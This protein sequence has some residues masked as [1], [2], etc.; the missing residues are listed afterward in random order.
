[1]LENVLA[2][3]IFGGLAG[4]IASIIAGTNQQM[5][6][7]ANVAVGI[8]GAIVGGAIVRL[9]GGAGTTGF[10]LY[11]LLVAILGAVVILWLARSLMGSSKPAKKK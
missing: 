5:G 7:V 2:W 6:V 9:I 8:V 4:W 3:V 10:N 1:M 11:S